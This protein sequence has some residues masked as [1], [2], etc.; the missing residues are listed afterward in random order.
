VLTARTLTAADRRRL[1]GRV[2]FVASKG[3]LDL[4]QLSTRLADLA[5]AGA[6]ASDGVPS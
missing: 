5:G 3:R 6:A 2:E 4:V 1:R